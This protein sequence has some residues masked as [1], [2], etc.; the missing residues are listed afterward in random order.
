MQIDIQTIEGREEFHDIG[1][2]LNNIANIPRG[3]LPLVRGLGLGW[4]SLSEVPEDM[5]SEYTVEAVEQFAKYEP[6]ISVREIQFQHQTD[7]ASRTAVIF[8]EGDTEE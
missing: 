6:R 8:E 7:G 2:C 3:S 1:R 5:E 4:E